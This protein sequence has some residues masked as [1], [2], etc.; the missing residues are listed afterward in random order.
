MFPQHIFNG[1]E[2]HL[3]TS[4][5]INFPLRKITENLYRRFYLY[6]NLWKSSIIIN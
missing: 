6:S 2:S 1:A 4:I 3:K 5:F